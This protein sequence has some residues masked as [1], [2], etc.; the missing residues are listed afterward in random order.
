MK[1]GIGLG[2]GIGC[3]LTLCLSLSLSG[4]GSKSDPDPVPE[5]RHPSTPATTNGYSR[6]MS[7]IEVRDLRKNYWIKEPA[8][9]L[10]SAVRQFI[11]PKRREVSAIEG[12]SFSVAPGERVAFVGPN[13]AGKSTTIKIL[14]GILHPSGGE[15][16]VLGLT[17]WTERKKLGARI[18]TVFG[19]RSQLWYHLPASDTFDLLARV[20]DLRW[21]DYQEVRRELV[22]AF[23]LEPFLHKPVRQLSLGERM[24]CEIVASLLHR[25]RILF[26]DEPT[27]GL[28]VS[29]K[30]VIRDL[31]KR[32]S[33]ELGTTLLLT[34]HDTGDMERVCE[35]AV[36]VHH[37]RL[38]LDR[39]IAQLRSHYIKRKLVTL[40]TAEPHITLELPG[41]TV[42]SAEPHRTVLEVDVA[43]SPVEKV[44][45]AAMRASSLN[46]LTVEDPPM[47]EIVKEI[48]ASA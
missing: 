9:G 21:N 38:I 47:E 22:S 41:I 45:E 30:S 40:L 16:R 36:V 6:S 44:V 17:P 33:Q 46:D 11:S 31:L 5:S 18:G 26:L 13:G 28:D 24:R 2:Y 32:K 27:I 42:V 15:V 37:G 48:Y 14:C 12:L 20:Y 35:R 10:R 19:Q 23:E 25:P 1:I 29:A 39:P 43:L 8:R 4:T 7:A 3:R 34:S